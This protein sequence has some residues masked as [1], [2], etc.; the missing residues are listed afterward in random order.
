MSEDAPGLRIEQDVRVPGCNGDSG[1]GSRRRWRGPGRG[2][3]EGVGRADRA[4]QVLQP[5]PKAEVGKG[6]L[7]PVYSITTGSW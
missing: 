1:G 4:V 6:G 3:D 5:T 7:L 2:D